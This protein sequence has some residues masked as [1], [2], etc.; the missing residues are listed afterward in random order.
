MIINYM[1]SRPWLDVQGRTRPA[2][3]IF[4]FLLVVG[5]LHRD[6]TKQ[7]S[8]NVPMYIANT[9]IN[10]SSFRHVADGLL[11]ELVK[12]L[13]EGPPRQLQAQKSTPAMKPA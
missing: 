11:N 1:L 2:S 8:L 10:A 4:K 13:E 9:K 12:R 5:L 6:L 3:R 7:G